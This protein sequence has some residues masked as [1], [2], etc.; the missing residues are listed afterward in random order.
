[1]E[2]LTI[3][4][5]TEIVKFAQ[6]YH[7][8]ALWMQDE[9]KIETNKLYPNMAKWNGHGLSIKYINSC[10]D[11][12]DGKIWSV[13]FRRGKDGWNFNSNHFGLNRTKPSEWRWNTL[14]E[15]CLGFLKGEMTEK[16]V[17][18]FETTTD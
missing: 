13:T 15:M 5:F 12:R 16:Q 14:K 8:F 11:S 2:A 18:Q 9:E 6:K 7:K 17:K 1:M 3:E 10:Y 4:E